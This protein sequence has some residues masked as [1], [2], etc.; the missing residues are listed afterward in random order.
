[1]CGIPNE[2]SPKYF[3]VN[4]AGE[5]F[6]SKHKISLLEVLVF[7]S[8]SSGL[9]DAFFPVSVVSL[10]WYHT[11][12]SGAGM[13]F[14]E[15]TDGGYPLSFGRHGLRPS[16]LV[17]GDERSQLQLSTVGFDCVFS[18]KPWNRLLFSFCVHPRLVCQLVD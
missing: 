17:D 8:S 18:P 12:K 11:P 4:V 14:T 6:V 5:Y 2:I 16:I 3:I 7:G 10:F 13:H 1:M 15:Y 9:G